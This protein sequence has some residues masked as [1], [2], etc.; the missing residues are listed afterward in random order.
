MSENENNVGSC[1]QGKEKDCKKTIVRLKN[2]EWIQKHL[3]SYFV[4]L[5]ARIT[6]IEMH[7]QCGR[8]SSIGRST[9]DLARDISS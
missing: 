5:D 9:P 2:I 3:C 1:H 8:Q 7:L 6:Y 4:S